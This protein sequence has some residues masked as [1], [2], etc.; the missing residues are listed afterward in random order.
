MISL[1]GVFCLGIAER[2]R[3][4][5]PSF[6]VKEGKKL[7]CRVEQQVSY[8]LNKVFVDFRNGGPNRKLFLLTTNVVHTLKEQN[9]VTTPGEMLDFWRKCRPQKSE[10]QTGWQAFNSAHSFPSAVLLTCEQC[11]LQNLQ[12]RNNSFLSR[13]CSKTRP[14]CISRITP[15]TTTFENCNLPNN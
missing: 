9:D 2:C 6:K 13:R 5:F 10:K 7:Q 1:G 8:N 3:E 14:T 12:K 4:W 11:L 15:W